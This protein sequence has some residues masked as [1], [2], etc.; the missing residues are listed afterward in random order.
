[1]YLY[2]AAYGPKG[3]GGG[4]PLP[5]RAATLSSPLYMTRSYPNHYGPY[6]GNPFSF[7]PIP[8]NK[9]SEYIKEK[10][11]KEKIHS[12][13]CLAH[14]P[15]RLSPRPPPRLCPHPPAPWPSHWR[16]CIPL[17]CFPGTPIPPPWRLCS[18]ATAG[19]VPSRTVAG[20]LYMTLSWPKPTTV[21]SSRAPHSPVP[22]SARQRKERD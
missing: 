12:K 4:L 20:S 11:S 2:L 19:P 15:L 22:Q 8:P 1:M 6:R 18:K 13:A 3:H 5:S 21:S 9:K 17:S 10:K 14:P 7:P 16:P